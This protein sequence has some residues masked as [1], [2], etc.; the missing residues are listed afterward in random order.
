MATP[1]PHRATAI[2]VRAL[3][4]ERAATGSRP[5]SRRD[6]HRLALCIEGG[7]MRGVVS[8]GMVAALEHLGLLYV[9]DRVYG[10]SAGAMN[11]AFFVAGQ[12]AFGSTIYY[13][14]I[15][16]NRFIDYRRAWRRRPIL[17]LDYLVWDVM[18]GTKRLDVARV[19]ASPVA[20][21]LLAT[22]SASGR[23]TTFSSW[24]DRE[25]FLGGL[26]AGASMP[27]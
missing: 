17:D 24:S 13:E 20:L 10:S 21:H 16:N 11:G 15:N 25:D 3:I 2:D 9:F 18:C 1:P 8:A 6:P 12:A 7:G 14:D 5:G 4:H 27:I 23:R 22:D 26:R 19:M